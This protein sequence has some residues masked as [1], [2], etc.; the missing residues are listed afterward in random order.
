MKTMN[1]SYLGMPAS[2]IQLSGIYTEVPSLINISFLS[3]KCQVAVFNI[4]FLYSSVFLKMEKFL[5][6]I[7]GGGRWAKLESGNMQF[8]KTRVG[9]KGV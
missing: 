9:S 7:L 5:K 3:I 1:S 4:L 8:L 6:E 2:H